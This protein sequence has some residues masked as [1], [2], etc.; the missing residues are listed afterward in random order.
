MK[1]MTLGNGLV[2][3]AAYNER[4][5]MRSVQVG[6]NGNSTAAWKAEYCWGVLEAGC[7]ANAPRS[8]NGNLQVQ[9]ISAPGFSVTQKYSYDGLNRI[10]KAEEPG[11][12][13]WTQDFVYD[14]W[15]NR[16]L[17]STSQYVDQVCTPLTMDTTVPFSAANNRWTAGAYDASGN[18]ESGCGKSYA[19]DGENRIGT[20]NGSAVTY[21]YDGQDRRVKMVEAGATTVWV[22][23]AFG[24]LAAEYRTG[25]AGVAAPCTTCYV[26]ADHLGSTRVV[27]SA[28]TATGDGTNLVMAR[29]DYLPF[30]EEI[31]AGW[32]ARTAGMGYAAVDGVRPRFTGQMRDGA[33]E[34]GLDYFGLRYMSAAQGR[35]TSP[36]PNSAGASLF[37]PQSWNAYSYVND[38]PLTHVDPDG[39]VPLPVITGLG[40]GIIGGVAGAFVE[41][42]AQQGLDPSQ[43]QS[44]KIWT[45]FGGGFVGGALAGLGLGG[46]AVGGVAVG[47][48][49]TAVLEGA[50]SVV[51]GYAQRRADEALGYA[52][53][54]QSE[55]LEI[56]ADA[57]SGGIGGAIGGKLGEHLIPLPNIR[58][59]LELLRFAHRQSTRAAQSRAAQRAFDWR[60]GISTA[61]GEAIENGIATP[62]TKS[63]FDWLFRPQPPPQ[64]LKSKVESEFRPCTQGDTSEGCR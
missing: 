13:P 18:F 60:A 20:V 4:L 54:P 46:L 23:D 34:S 31:P 50:G 10:L 58:K 12:S 30:G 6:V 57:I 7:A 24:S 56:A 1:Q 2:E 38:R 52:Q 44:G 21:S 40:G 41:Y 8:N 16:A 64:A 62:L 32:G 36:D 47:A 14:R 59:Q 9:T 26:T 3:Q 25:M 37:D 61:V 28:G 19:Y 22:Y 49:T 43:R 29:H 45:A 42:R 39:D 15:G 53:A 35:F 33:T 27:T 5:Q 11:V 48:G 17:K 63:V 51:G 55:G